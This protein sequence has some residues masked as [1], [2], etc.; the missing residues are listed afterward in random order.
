MCRVLRDFSLVDCLEFP[1]RVSSF[2]VANGQVGGWVSHA[3]HTLQ[4]NFGLSAHCAVQHCTTPLFV[5]CFVLW[6]FCCC[7]LNQHVPNQTARGKRKREAVEGRT[8]TNYR[9][10]YL[11]PLDPLYPLPFCGCDRLHNNCD[12]PPPIVSSFLLFFPFLST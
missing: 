11:P 10:I 12:T 6:L 1:F 7:F 5:C 3:T 8:N 2:G 9:P 4:S